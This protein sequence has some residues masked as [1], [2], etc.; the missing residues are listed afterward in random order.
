MSYNVNDMLKITLKINES[1]IQ[2][3]VLVIVSIYFLE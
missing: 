2:Q 1:I 3:W